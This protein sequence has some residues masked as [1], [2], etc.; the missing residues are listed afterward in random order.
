[1]EFTSVKKQ[2]WSEIKEIY[3]EAFPKCERKPFFLLRQSIKRKKAVLAVAEE[4][5]QLLGFTVFVVY[6]DMVMI[7]YLAV[8][9]KIRSRG[10][11][12]RILEHIC[13]QFPDKKI[14]LLIE[15]VDDMAENCQQRT[16]RRRFYLKNGFTSSGIFIT[17]AGG[18]MEVLNYG[19]TVSQE[20]YMDLQRY[21]LG[22]LFFRLSRIQLAE[23]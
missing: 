2:Q 4:G 15:R 21:A 3:M 7:D 1:M 19:G 17:G 12:S 6:K 22:K 9:S 10:T 13:G 14:V 20:E 16:A 5:N 11:G 23:V 8:S 18:D